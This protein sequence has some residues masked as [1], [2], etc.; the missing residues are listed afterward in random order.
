MLLAAI[1]NN[2]FVIHTVNRL[3]SCFQLVKAQ[4]NRCLPVCFETLICNAC[5]GTVFSYDGIVRRA[6]ELGWIEFIEPSR[7]HSS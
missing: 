6:V 4:H 5:C 2:C 3:C 7:S 1:N